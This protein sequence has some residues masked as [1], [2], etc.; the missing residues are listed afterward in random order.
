MRSITVILFASILA[1]AA[2]AQE[3]NCKVSVIAPQPRNSFVFKSTL[4]AG[5]W[6]LCTTAQPENG[7]CPDLPGN[8]SRGNYTVSATVKTLDG[9]V[10]AAQTFFITVYGN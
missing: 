9:Q 3:F 8:L 6:N 5:T 7:V 10:R 2:R 4:I 1:V